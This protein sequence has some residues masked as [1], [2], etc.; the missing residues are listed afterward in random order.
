MIMNPDSIL[1]I[2]RQGLDLERAR[3]EAAARALEIADTPIPPGQAGTG[4]GRADFGGRLSGVSPDREVHDPTNPMADARGMV[5]YPAVDTVGQMSTLI[6]ATRAYEANVRA[7]NALRSM[8]LSALD[9]GGT[10]S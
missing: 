7:F 9:I 8:E 3:L 5:H 1:S 10:Q 6:S 4:A 2:S